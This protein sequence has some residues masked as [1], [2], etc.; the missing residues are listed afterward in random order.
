MFKKFKL[1]PSPTCLWCEEHR[2]T[3]N[4]FIFSPKM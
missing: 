1:V 3:D 4:G 2:K